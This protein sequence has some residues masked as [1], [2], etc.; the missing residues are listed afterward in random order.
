MVI[1]KMSCV[2]L[3]EGKLAF[4][5]NNKAL[6]L[7]ASMVF[8]SSGSP[9]SMPAETCARASIRKDNIYSTEFVFSLVNQRC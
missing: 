7:N 9:F 2:S 5:V 3:N 6:I 4:A 8:H 1:I